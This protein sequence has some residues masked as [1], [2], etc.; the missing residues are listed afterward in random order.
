[1]LPPQK[2][3]RL[4]QGGISLGKRSL[5]WP[6]Q[7]HWR[8]P[9]F[10]KAHGCPGVQEQTFTAQAHRQGCSL[11]NDG[12]QDC[13]SL[14]S[15]S[16]LSEVHTHHRWAS[17]RMHTERSPPLHHPTPSAGL[18]V[19]NGLPVITAPAGPQGRGRDP[20]FLLCLCSHSRIRREVELPLWAQKAGARIRPQRAQRQQTC[21]HST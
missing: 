6:L 8:Q 4:R 19:Q 3:A 13:P 12:Q 1:M 2:P 7:I 18:G 14:Q 5:P 16:H 11:Q 10:H 9:A 20:G 15:S 17:G 21:H